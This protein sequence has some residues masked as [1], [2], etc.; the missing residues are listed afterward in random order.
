MAYITTERVSEIRKELKNLYPDFKFSISRDRFSTVRIVILEAPIPLT[1]KKSETVNVYW[2]KERKGIQKEIFT[3]IVE[4]ANQGVKHYETGDYGT[5][6]SHYVDLLVGDW[7]K[8]FK[9]VIRNEKNKPVFGIR[10]KE[11]KQ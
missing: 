5:Q 2:I 4:I 9:M 7:D 11:K 6:P 8:P 1:E 3:Q 10:L